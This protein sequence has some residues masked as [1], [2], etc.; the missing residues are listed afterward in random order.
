ML[1][2]REGERLPDWLEAAEASGI[3]ELARFAGKLRADQEAVQAG[4]TLRH[5]NGQTEGQVTKLKLIKR[6]GYGRAKVD[7]LRKRRAAG[8]LTTATGRQ[9]LTANPIPQ[10]PQVR[11][12]QHVVARCITRRSKIVCR[13]FL[14]ADDSIEDSWH[15]KQY[16]VRMLLRFDCPDSIAGPFR[17]LL[18]NEAETIEL[19]PRW[20]V[21]RPFPSRTRLPT[22]I[23]KITHRYRHPPAVRS[24]TWRRIPHPR[25]TRS[26]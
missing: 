17:I 22:E 25:R 11:E 23:R 24:A 1:R 15:D 16:L 5:S 21:D 19:P 10:S 14:V 6:Q 3:D 4:L 2:R 12:S 26:N 13:R 7:L 8:G 9:A 18:V 20:P